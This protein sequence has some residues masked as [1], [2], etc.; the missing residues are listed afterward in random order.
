M[1]A[2][3]EYA[4]RVEKALKAKVEGMDCLLYTSKILP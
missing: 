4:A 3:K 1:N 2:L